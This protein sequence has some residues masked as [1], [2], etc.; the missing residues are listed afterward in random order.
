MFLFLLYIDK[1]KS[2][3]FN[4]KNEKI[5]VNIN[6]N[7]DFPPVYFIKG[8]IENVLFEFVVIIS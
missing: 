2:E 8:L 3:H 5:Y 1:G 4:L 7:M 6:F